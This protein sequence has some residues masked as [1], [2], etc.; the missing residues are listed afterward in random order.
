M[1]FRIQ[2]FHVLSSDDLL[3]ILPTSNF[4][5]GQQQHGQEGTDRRPTEHMDQMSFHAGSFCIFHWVHVA[6]STLHWASQL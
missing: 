6:L 5:Q 2:L 4:F 1:T 3:C